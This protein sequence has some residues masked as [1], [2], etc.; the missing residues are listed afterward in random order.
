MSEQKVIRVVSH[1]EIPGVYEMQ[2]VVPLGWRVV[3]ISPMGGGGGG[4][5]RIFHFA[6]L[7]VIEKR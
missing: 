4:E 3:M 2:G 5:S 1:D 6:A 7:V